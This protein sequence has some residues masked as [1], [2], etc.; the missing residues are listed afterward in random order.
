MKPTLSFSHMSLPMANP[1]QKSALPD[2][3]INV[4]QQNR[5]LADSQEDEGLYAGYGQR[6]NAYPYTQRKG[7]DRNLQPG[8]LPTAILENDALRA[9]FLPSLGGRLW[10]LTD[11][12]ADRE[13]LYVNDV[14]R[15]SDLAVCG[16]WFSG[17][18]EWNIGLI[19]HSPFTTEPLFTAATK[20]ASGA[21]VLRMYEY[22]QVRGVC[23]QMDFW[24]EEENHFLNCRMRIENSSADTTPMY[25]WS[26]IAV[27]EDACGR[28]A[29]PA[30]SAYTH[31]PQG[32]ICKTALPLPD[33]TDVTR[34][35]SIA[36]PTD[37]FFDIPKQER[38]Y[39]AAF[40]GDGY[41]LLQLS[42]QRLQGRKMFH[43]GH[44]ASS[45]KWQEY[46]TETAGPYLEVQAG[47]A[48][49]Q[50]GCLP[51]PGNTVWEWLEQYGPIQIDPQTLSLPLEPFQHAVSQTVEDRFMQCPPEALL[52]NSASM[53][54]TPAKLHSCGSGLG[55]LENARRAAEQEKNLPL[56]L[57]FGGGGLLAGWVSWFSGAAQAPTQYPLAEP[58]AFF[59]GEKTYNFLE[60]QA[61]KE[62]AGNW[63]VQYQAGIGCMMQAKN[64]KAAFFFQRSLDLAPNPWAYHA[65]ACLRLNTGDQKGAR[66]AILNGVSLCADKLYYWMETF[67]ILSKAGFPEEIKRLWEALPEETASNK[68]L[69]FNYISAL[70]QS[71]DE[72]QAMELLMQN[73]GLVPDDIHEGDHSLGLLYCTLHQRLYGTRPEIP[74]SLDFRMSP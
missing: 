45:H 36:Y 26:N 18:V 74:P 13:L 58:P 27:P 2:L 34:Y 29:V 54:A 11:K 14:L 51:M 52:A 39:I 72:E 55:A 3:L 43:W 67:R 19:G 9:V 73:G 37:Y 5:R 1:G 15:Y 32:E 44:A 10:S 16:A 68:R 66:E 62:E 63:L 28:I 47:L 21:P 40:S 25:W 4:N 6:S 23:F 60:K 41:G 64:E 12:V 65:L 70:S 56:H 59:Y 22:E 49:T 38:K 17:G 7:Y 61:E 48:K 35:Q 50:Y 69:T 8:I 20:T 71:G 30:T 53:A 46:L 31:N 33:G 42:T 24:L 57:D